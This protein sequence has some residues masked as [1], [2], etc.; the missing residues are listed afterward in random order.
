MAFTLEH[1]QQVRN[2]DPRVVGVLTDAVWKVLS[3]PCPWVYLGQA[4][5]KHIRKKPP[6][7][8][9]FD[10]LRMPLAIAAGLLMSAIGNCPGRPD[11]PPLWSRGSRGTQQQ[12]Q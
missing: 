2:G 4:G 3:W 6:D 11:T 1:A 10:L 5:I 8:T 7:V 12:S 9:D